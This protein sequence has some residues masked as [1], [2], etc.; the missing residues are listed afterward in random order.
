MG[1][2]GRVRGGDGGALSLVLRIGARVL[3][4]KPKVPIILPSPWWPKLIEGGMVALASPRSPFAWALDYILPSALCSQQP[5][6]A[7]PG[8]RSQVALDRRLQSRCTPHG[9]RFCL[10]KAP[11]TGRHPPPRLRAVAAQEFVPGQT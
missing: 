5:L 1:R 2:S 6:L 10:E 8:K 11:L 7:V 3:L 9:G 4:S